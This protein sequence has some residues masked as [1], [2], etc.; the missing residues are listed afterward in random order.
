MIASCTEAGEESAVEAQRHC[1]SCYVGVVTMVIQ[2]V[3]VVQL[4]LACCMPACNQAVHA[5]PG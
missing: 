4:P 5:Q 1:H 2:H 3:P